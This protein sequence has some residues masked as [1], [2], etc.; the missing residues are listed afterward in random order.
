MTDRTLSQ[1]ADYLSQRRARML[2]VLGIVYF[3]QQTTYFRSTAAAQPRD[4]DKLWISAWLLLSLLLLLGVATRGFWFRSRALREM[5]DDENTR[6]NR[7]E[8]IR[9]GFIVAMLTGMGVYVATAFTPMTAREAVHIILTLGLGAALIRFGTL[10]RR[11]LRD[12]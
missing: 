5:I 7:L 8:G 6:A 1:Q 12:G 11:A 3:L 9:I 10:E 2:P 4:V